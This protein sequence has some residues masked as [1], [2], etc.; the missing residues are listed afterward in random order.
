MVTQTMDLIGAPV[1]PCAGWDEDAR[2]PVAVG[3]DPNNR[4]DFHDHKFAFVNG[5]IP[6]YAAVGEGGLQALDVL[7]MSPRRRS[8]CQM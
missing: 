5:I 3:S 6:V 8:F 1:W 2:Q 7:G 4:E